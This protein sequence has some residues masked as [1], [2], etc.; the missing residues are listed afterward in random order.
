MLEAAEDDDDEAPLEFLLKKLTIVPR[1]AAITAI[2]C[3]LGS[4]PK[5]GP[6]GRD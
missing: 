6:T 3:A 1:V 5:E 2:C 4:K